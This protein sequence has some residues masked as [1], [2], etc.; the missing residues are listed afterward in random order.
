MYSYVLTVWGRCT[1]GPYLESRP[2]RSALNAC[3]WAEMLRLK[4][5]EGDARS[6][7]GAFVSRPSHKKKLLAVRLSD[8]WMRGSF[9]SMRPFR[10][11]PHMATE[12]ESGLYATTN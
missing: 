11:I 10:S 8:F 12:A 2:Q 9:D 3:G 6:E 5:A 7:S 4:R 1:T